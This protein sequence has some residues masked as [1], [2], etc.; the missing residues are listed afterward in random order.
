MR[1]IGKFGKKKRFV[2]KTLHKPQ[3]IQ[4]NQNPNNLPTRPKSDILITFFRIS[5]FRIFSQYSSY[6]K[7]KFNFHDCQIIFPIT[8]I[9]F[10]ITP[11]CQIPPIKS[12]KLYFIIQHTI[13]TLL[14]RLFTLQITFHQSDFQKHL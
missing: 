14:Q 2:R 13:Y 7:N 11:M 6:S 9:R 12:A 8:S 3:P 4:Q 10:S 1:K 5:K